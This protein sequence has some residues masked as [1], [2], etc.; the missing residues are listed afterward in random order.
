[1]FIACMILLSTV[2]LRSHFATKTV[3]LP[4]EAGNDNDEVQHQIYPLTEQNIEYMEHIQGDT[5]EDDIRLRQLQDLEDDMQSIDDQEYDDK[6]EREEVER[7]KQTFW[8]R[9]RLEG[10]QHEMDEAF[11]GEKA[12]H[13]HYERSSTSTQAT[14]EL[15]LEPRATE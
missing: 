4:M 9:S 5:Q 3:E 11:R 2:L 6:R 10:H 12:R 7:P 8:M 13:G 15:Q 1:M 14:L